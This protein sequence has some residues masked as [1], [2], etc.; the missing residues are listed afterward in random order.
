[1]QAVLAGAVSWATPATSVSPAG[2][3]AI[4]GSGL[5]ASA[6]YVL[7]AIQA[8]GNA[9]ALTINA[10]DQAITAFQPGLTTGQPETQP[11]PR[12][13]SGGTGSTSC[14]PT[15]I[16]EANRRGETAVLTETGWT[17]KQQPASQ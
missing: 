8:T 10:S 13:Q 16:T 12:G 11:L 9:A 14:S 15:G 17:C 1:M 5:T 3:Y 6:N 2:R 7:T 4:N